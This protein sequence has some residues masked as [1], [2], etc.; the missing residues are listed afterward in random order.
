[1]GL[2]RPG[3]IPEDLRAMVT[4]GLFQSRQILSATLSWN[5]WPTLAT[6]Q[7]IRVH[8]PGRRMRLAILSALNKDLQAI[9]ESLCSATR[10]RILLRLQSRPV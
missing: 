8:S 2:V 4:A 6:I 1:M 10:G 5:R 7:T 9:P 3:P